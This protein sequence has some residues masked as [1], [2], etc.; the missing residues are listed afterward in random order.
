VIEFGFK[1][2]APYS[3]EIDAKGEIT[4]KG[5]RNLPELPPVPLSFGFERS[6][7]SPSTVK[8]LVQLA[9]ALDFWK[10]P[11]AI[12]EDSSADTVPR[13][14]TVNLSCA[15]HL[16]VLRDDSKTSPEVQRFA[17]MYML[18]SDLVYDEPGT[19]KPL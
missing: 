13:Y 2:K 8:A 16:V 12:G 1:G 14:M 15:R 3:V 10:L 7:V 9:S 18:L 6:S 4:A 19:Y 17:E 11:S 5:A